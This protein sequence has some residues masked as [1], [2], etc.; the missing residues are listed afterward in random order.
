MPG[1]LGLANWRRLIAEQ[2]FHAFLRRI[3]NRRQI[4]ASFERQ[5]H[6]SVGQLHQLAREVAEAR[7]RHDVPAEGRRVAGG[8]VEAG[9]DE[10][11]VRRELAGDRHH[12]GPERGQVLGVA[13]RRRHAARPRDV[14]VEAQPGARPALRGAAGARE[15][16]AVVVPVDREVEHAAVLVEHL[17]RAVAVVHVPVDDQHLAD[18]G[19]PLPQQPRRDRDGVEEAEAHRLVGLGVVAGRPH[20]REP[21]A[22][23]AL[24]RLERQVD[25]AAGGHAGRRARVVLVPGGVEVD[26]DAAAGQP[27]EAGARRVDLLAVQLVRAEQ[28]RVVLGVHRLHLLQRRLAR[29][30]PVAA[31]REPRLAEARPHALQPAA[32]L[33]V[34]RVVAARARV[35]QHRVVEREAGGDVVLALGQ[36]A[37]VRHAQVHRRRPVDDDVRLLAQVH[38]RAGQGARERPR[39]PERVLDRQLHRLPDEQLAL[40]LQVLLVPKSFLRWD[41]RRRHDRARRHRFG[42]LLLVGQVDHLALLL[43]ERVGA[44]GA[45]QHRL[46]DLLREQQVLLERLPLRVAVLVVRLADAQRRRAGQHRVAERQRRRLGAPERPVALLVEARVRHLGVGDRLAEHGRHLVQ[47]QLRQMHRVGVRL[48]RHVRALDRRQPGAVVHASRRDHR[49]RRRPQRGEEALKA[50]RAR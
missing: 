11:E 27:H 24:G 16:V 3:T 7:G 37:P 9:R 42:R 26:A 23:V 35:L 17:L 25:H 4:V 36:R 47:P 2:R 28:E 19:Q 20:H 45:R 50:E 39:Q 32:V 48:R 14:H 12:D 40:L 41:R 30:Q 1:E 33:G 38:Q 6:L 29:P 34:R 10:H 43:L 13:E 49:L 18:L 46:P 31:R 44:A 15:E 21:V 22:D 8:R 5:H